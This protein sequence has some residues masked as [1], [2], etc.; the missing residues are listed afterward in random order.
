MLGDLQWL[1]QSVQFTP[2]AAPPALTTPKEMEL[3]RVFR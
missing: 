2:D 1:A 3:A